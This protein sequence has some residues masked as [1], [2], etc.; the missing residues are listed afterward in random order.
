MY[1]HAIREEKI[2][3]IK[4]TNLVFALVMFGSAH[5]ETYVMIVTMKGSA[6]PATLKKYC[7]A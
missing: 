1:S 2:E 5:D 4:R 6:M 7:A 3:T